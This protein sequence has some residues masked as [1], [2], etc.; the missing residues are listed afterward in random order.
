MRLLAN[1]WITFLCITTRRGRQVSRMTVREQPRAYVVC[2]RDRKDIDLPPESILLPTV[3]VSVRKRSCNKFFNFV[4][5]LIAS[6][7]SYWLRIPPKI[8][9][10]QISLTKKGRICLLLYFSK[11]VRTPG[12]TVF[13]H[14]ISFSFYHFTICSIN[15]TSIIVCVAKWC[16]KWIL[17]IQTIPQPW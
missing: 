15:L 11:V 8:S 1:I 16:I 2:G 13:I 7:A 9:H 3:N 5:P 12:N 14:F 4:N 17:L 10:N 6:M